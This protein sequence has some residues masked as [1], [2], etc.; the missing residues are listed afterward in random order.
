MWQLGIKQTNTTT[1]FVVH[2]YQTDQSDN[3]MHAGG[4]QTPQS[5]N[6][7]CGSWVSDGPIIQYY[8]WQLGIRHTNHTTLFLAAGYQK[9]QSDDTIC[10]SWASEE[11]S[12][13][14]VCGSWVSDG[15]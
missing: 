10:G 11:Q 12:D 4:Y 15:P 9:D 8:I 3:T 13:N 5:D 1:L 6:T 7:I 14:A 2:G